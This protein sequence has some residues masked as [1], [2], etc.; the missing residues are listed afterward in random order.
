MSKP[1]IKKS[2][3]KAS[4]FSKMAKLLEFKKDESELFEALSVIFFVA[5]QPSP[6]EN[7]SSI[8]AED[9]FDKYG[10]PATDSKFKTVNCGFCQQRV[11]KMPR[12]YTLPEGKGADMIL[13]DKIF[14]Y[15]ASRFEQWKQITDPAL[16]RPFETLKERIEAAKSNKSLDDYE[17]ITAYLKARDNPTEQAK[18][19]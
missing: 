3:W 11:M 7:K 18:T 5:D 10:V 1:K 15:I 8:K 17:K 6:A 14:E 13:D 19:A 2:N 16:K 9:A 12:I 4:K